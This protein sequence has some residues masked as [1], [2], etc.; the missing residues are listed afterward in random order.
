VLGREA[1]AGCDSEQA[2]RLR[3]EAEER[4]FSLWMTDTVAAAVE[5]EQ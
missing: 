2:V 5:G 1:V 4:D 3:E